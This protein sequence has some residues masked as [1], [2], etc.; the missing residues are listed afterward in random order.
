MTGKDGTFELPGDLPPGK[1][2]ITAW[3]EKHKTLTKQVEV[4]AGQTVEIQFDFKPKKGGR[5]RR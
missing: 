4:K 2:T 1:Y 3:H 5:R